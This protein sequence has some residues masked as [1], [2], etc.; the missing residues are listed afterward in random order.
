ME[1]D[2]RMAVITDRTEQIGF[3]GGQLHQAW[4]AAVRTLNAYENAERS[5]HRM[6]EVVAILSAELEAEECMHMSLR[7]DSKDPTP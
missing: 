4:R 2:A 1:V 7:R 5:D 6:H 3:L